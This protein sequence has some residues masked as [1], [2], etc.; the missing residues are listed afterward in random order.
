MQC[1]ILLKEM[2][3]A[4]AYRKYT[5][6]QHFAALYLD[7]L[8]RPER[9]WLQVKT[10]HFQSIKNER[11]MTIISDLVM[12]RLINMINMHTSKHKGQSR[13]SDLL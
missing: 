6:C 1:A 8:R 10:Y 11:F 4:Y 7:Y 3:G 2:F 12:N 9:D 5:I 13:V